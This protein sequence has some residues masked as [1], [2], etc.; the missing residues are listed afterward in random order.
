MNTTTARPGPS[1]GGFSFAC[2]P[3]YP[4]AAPRR[5]C[6]VL[7][8]AGGIFTPV[9]SRT[10]ERPKNKNRRKGHLQA[11]IAILALGGVPIFPQSKTPHR[12]PQTALQGIKQPRPAPSGVSRGFIICSGPWIAPRS[13]PPSGHTRRRRRPCTSRCPGIHRPARWM[14]QWQQHGLNPSVGI[15]AGA[16]NLLP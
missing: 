12:G 1:W 13:A 8:P 10:V 14:L 6:A 3:L 15:V 2:V 11:R 9:A 7:R 5:L 16:Q 4:P